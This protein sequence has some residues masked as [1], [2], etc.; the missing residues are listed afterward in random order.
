MA[1]DSSSKLQRAFQ[2]LKS[3]L[4]KLQPCASVDNLLRGAADASSAGSLAPSS[5]SDGSE[6]KSSDASSSQQPT[7]DERA[8]CSQV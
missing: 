2:N 8:T 3:E 5:T 1:D 6:Q 7:D 4:C